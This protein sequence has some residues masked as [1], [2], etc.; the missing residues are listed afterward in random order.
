[1]S[2]DFVEEKRIVSNG[3]PFGFARAPRAKIEE[4]TVPPGKEFLIEAHMLFETVPEE[5]RKPGA[6]FVRVQFV[7]GKSLWESNEIR[8]ELEK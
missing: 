8:V 3:Q 6:Y 5:D 7:V 1:V 2:A 4:H